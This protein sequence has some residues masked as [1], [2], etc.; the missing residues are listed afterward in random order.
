MKTK[1]K[2]L[3]ISVLA[4]V[5]L[6]NL[7]QDEKQ[8]MTTAY[9]SSTRS[10]SIKQNESLL[11]NKERLLDICKETNDMLSAAYE[12]GLQE[13]PG[14]WI[15]TYPW[16]KLSCNQ[17][18]LSLQEDDR[19]AR[20]NIDESTTSVEVTERA[21]DNDI[22]LYDNLSNR[23]MAK[24]LQKLKTGEKLRILAIGGSMTRGSVDNWKFPCEDVYQRAWPKKIQQVMEEKWGENSV[25]VINIA[26]GGYN[27]DAWLSSMNFIVGYAPVDIILME[28]AVN[29]RG[30][31]RT[32]KWD[33]ERVAETSDVLLN[34]LMRIPG[35]PAVMSVELFTLSSSDK[36]DANTVCPG[37]VQFVNDPVLDFEQC[38]YCEF[39]WMPQTWRDTVRKKN[40]VA[41]VSYR[42]A[43]WPVQSLPPNNL[44][45]FWNGVNHPEVATHA[46][47][48]STVVF[49][50]FI[51]METQEE[52]ATLS[53]DENAIITLPT[54]A[55]PDNACLE[56]TTSINAIQGNP[57]DQMNLP[58]DGSS[59]W[60]FR[61]DSR[62]KYGWICEFGMD[63]TTFG[64]SDSQ[65]ASSSRELMKG[66]KLNDYLTLKQEIHLGSDGKLIVTRLRSWDSRMAKADVWLSTQT[67]E[68]VFEGD[69][70]WT[71]DSSTDSDQA[72]RNVSIAVPWFTHIR[73]YHFKH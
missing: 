16:F 28:S 56:P 40:S 5:L 11:L 35:K 8:H 22:F 73:K 68:N 33:A 55:M 39:M 9:V 12:K 62:H 25:E 58:K 51:I 43:V 17:L 47:V 31:Y 37:H 18:V 27:E 4:F 38:F 64:L 52:L 46:L 29:D 53:H 15:S 50:L 44:C 71:I 41:R 42:D 60:I 67:G 7:I 30:L 19:A 70:V 36:D 1:I 10:L 45:Q 54:V 3:L 49:H 59:C 20:L 57:I 48:A 24:K 23:R 26:L 13:E 61:S 6:L 21:M 63:G 34:L 69:P 66:H 65:T 72:Q 2:V 32:Q 14:Y